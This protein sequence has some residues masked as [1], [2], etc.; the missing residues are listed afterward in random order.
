[1]AFNVIK[2][3]GL[4]SGIPHGV[5]FGNPSS[6]YACGPYKTQVNYFR[7]LDGSGVRLMSDRRAN[8]N[9]WHIANIYWVMCK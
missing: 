2:K 1:M 4:I 5:I 7:V 6:G 9:S 3:S 8:F